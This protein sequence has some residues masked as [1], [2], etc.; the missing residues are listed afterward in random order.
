M[1]RTLRYASAVGVLGALALLVVGCARPDAPPAPAAAIADPHAK[2]HDEPHAHKPSARGGLIV[3]IGGDRYHA[4]AVFEKGGTLRLY[5]L[6]R[7]ESTVLE[8]ESQTLK[9]HVRLEDGTETEPLELAPRPQPDDRPNMTSLFVAQLPREMWGK[10]VVVTVP[11]IRING[12]R[13]R[14]AFVSSPAGDGHDMPAP[15]GGDEERKL[16][17]TPGG[18][19]TAADIKAN[20]NQVASVKFKGIKATH[21]LKPKPGDRLCPISM[22]KANPKFTWI[23]GGK[24]YEFCCPPCVDEFV[25]TAKENPDEIKDPEFYVKK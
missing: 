2:G 22:T 12:E 25:A 9:A 5:M 17:L 19:Y 24:S 6:G 11:S 8:V 4:E 7:D 15:V 20:G 23:V 10:P 14:L 21:D 1:V 3:P 16:Y 18:M 13:L